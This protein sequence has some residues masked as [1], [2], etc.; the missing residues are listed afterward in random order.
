MPRVE[1][2][3]QRRTLPPTLNTSVTCTAVG[4][5][6]PVDSIT[7]YK[8]NALI[9]RNSSSGVHYNTQNRTTSSQYGRYRCLIDTKVTVIEKEL[10]LQEEGNR[11][12]YSRTMWYVV[13]FYCLTATLII[14]F[15]AED[16]SMWTVSCWILKF[17]SQL[18]LLRYCSCRIHNC[19][20]LNHLSWSYSLTTVVSLF[21][22][23]QLLTHPSVAPPPPS[24]SPPHSSTPLTMV[25]WLHQTW[26]TWWR[27]R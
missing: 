13:L 23:H 24:P 10:L 1:L 8:N 14:V 16:C 18:S 2:T 11:N 6:P 12:Y 15:R 26:S 5:Y 19:Q 7:L 9:M 27:L 25:S 4:G 22:E 17:Y 3:T 20:I 21:K